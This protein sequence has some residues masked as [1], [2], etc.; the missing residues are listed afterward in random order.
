M[1]V[2]STQNPRFPVFPLGLTY[3][4]H[5]TLSFIRYHLQLLI[6]VQKPIEVIILNP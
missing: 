3:L 2:L 5:S 6:A 1:G 4:T